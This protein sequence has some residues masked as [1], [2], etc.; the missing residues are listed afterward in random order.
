MIRMLFL[1]AALSSV[2]S[3][4]TQ[5]EQK[6]ELYDAMAYPG[7][8]N[9]APEGLLPV[10]LMYEA[11]LTKPDPANPSK[12]VLDLEKI[13]VQ[14]EL[15]ANFPHVMVSTDIENWYGDNSIDASEMSNRFSQLFSVFR[16]K[17]PNVTIGNYGIVPSALC[18]Y[19]F[20]DDGKTEDGVLIDKWKEN[21]IK[22]WPSLARADVC[23]PS[24]YI[25]QPDI[26]S[27]KRDLQITVA[28]IKKHNPNKK[29]IVYIWPQYYNK[30]DSPYGKQFLTG[31][32]WASL[33]EAVYESCDG[34]IIWSGQTDEK[35]EVARWQD[36]RIQ[37]IWNA[38]KDFITLHQGN[39]K[40]PTPESFHIEN[41]NP[42][43]SFI[44]YSS[45]NYTGTPNLAEHGLHNYRIAK[46]SDLSQFIDE[47]GIYEPDLSKIAHLAKTSSSDP[48]LILNSSWIKDRRSNNE[49]MNARFERVQQVFKQNSDKSQL[50]FSTVGPTGLSSLRTSNSNFFVNLSSWMFS[51]VSPTRS[52]RDFVDALLPNSYIVD[53][54][55]A[56]W[57]RE[58][59][60]TINEARLNNNSKPIYAYIYSDYFNQTANFSDAYKLIKE[61][62]WLTM[63]ETAFKLCDGVVIR[64]IGNS[65]WDEEAGFWKATKHFISTHKDNIIFPSDS[66]DPNQENNIIQN[67]S[68]ENPIKPSA[69][70]TTYGVDYVAP[71]R[72]T[73]FF[74]EMSQTSNPASVPTQIF[75]NVWFERGTS[76]HQC[77]LNV[78]NTK[79]FSGAKSMII[80]NVGGSTS[81]A[82]SKMYAYH[83]LAQ[84]V[85]LN[86]SK[87]Y[88]FKFYVQRDF[89]Y[90]NSPNLIN[91]LH[92]GIISSTGALPASNSTYYE[93][94]T[95][96]ENESWNE[97]S[98]IFDLPAIIESVPGKKFEKCAVFIAMKTGWDSEAGRTLQSIVNVDDVS[99]REIG[100]T[101]VRE[102]KKVPSDKYFKIYREKLTIKGNHEYFYIY[103]LRGNML[104]QNRS[105]VDGFTYSFSNKGIYI[106]SFGR[107]SFKVLIN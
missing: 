79:S 44:I 33:L 67:G 21:N 12:V 102:I 23:T 75:D 88:E 82:T 73:G 14:A 100:T 94:I 26:E 13:N 55:T 85:S 95:I 2:F 87:K 84:K 53:D 37:E 17:N 59:L 52:L 25:A 69:I 39:L 40:L 99:L 80:F 98:V 51:A 74:D 57:K 86:D 93:V 47:N 29:I 4:Y 78:D 11:T 34:A 72:T 24:V 50:W 6:F 46:E 97:V 10:Y 31:E 27:W 90:R 101:S 38:T 36:T 19:R 5:R 65:P 41:N 96:P 61:A 60:L 35:E 8:P 28:E 68:F 15:A 70:E 103:D 54:D 81:D 89:E 1:I 22:R 9:L 104:Y 107:Q 83:N 77:R 16:G 58:F 18:V 3:G 56:V 76:Q 32:K 49:A 92:V 45:I 62:T 48:V 43:K 30:P 42:D 63:L 105:V 106:I 64:N 91:E 66:N 71:L 7:K 20:Y